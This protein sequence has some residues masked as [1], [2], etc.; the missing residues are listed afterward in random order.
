MPLQMIVMKKQS[1]EVLQYQQNQIRNVEP[2]LS[3]SE[4][5]RPNSRVCSKAE[6]FQTFLMSLAGLNLAYF[7]VS[8]CIEVGL[9]Q[10]LTEA[11]KE[12]FTV[13]LSFTFLLTLV[14]V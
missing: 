12:H 11:V 1:F 8:L 10:T 4:N 3:D 2:C 6:K 14:K 9:R 7:I 5:N 13:L